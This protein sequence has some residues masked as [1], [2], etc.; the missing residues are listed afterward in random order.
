VSSISSRGLEISEQ[1]SKKM[2]TVM[3]SGD[4]PEFNRTEGDPVLYCPI[5]FNY[6]GI[7]GL[8]TAIRQ[9]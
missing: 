5:N 6:R 7:D 1:I 2:D 8:C 3:F 4:F 9:G